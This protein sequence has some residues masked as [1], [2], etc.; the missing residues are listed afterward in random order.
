[1]DSKTINHTGGLLAAFN[2]K[3][4]KYLLN[5]YLFGFSVA[6]PLL[7]Y[8][9]FGTNQSYSDHGVGNGN[10][11]G[12]VLIKMTLYGVFT[13]LSSVGT[14][15]VL[16]RDKGWFRQM[17]V[18]PIGVRRYVTASILASLIL[19]FLII[20][21]CFVVGVFTGAHMLLSVWI[22]SVILI[23]LV[24]LI[25]SLLGM[26][27]AFWLRSEGAFPVL[28]GVILISAFLSGLFIPL[29]NMGSFFQ[30]LAP[31]SPLYGVVKLSEVHITQGSLDWKWVLNLVVWSV[32]FAVITFAGARRRH[33]RT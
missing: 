28:S 29:D 31:Y 6:I 26:G 32:V 12:L 20:A 27:V 8:L 22:T 14:N 10:V 9:I 13:A 18:I 7:M 1:M 15:I 5:P 2:F 23:L 25:G 3:L 16:E 19:A 33:D 30:K 11:A 4:Q 21:I 17:S 24:S